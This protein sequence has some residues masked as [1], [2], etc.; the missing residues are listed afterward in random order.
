[1]TGAEQAIIASDQHIYLPAGFEPGWIYELVY[2][3]R[4]PLALD[5]GFAALRDLVSSL[6]ND[7]SPANPLSGETKHPTLFYG[8]GR[9]QSGRLIRDFV[10]RGY[11]DDGFG[12][13]VFDGMI[14]HVAGAGRTA[15]NR[16]SNLVV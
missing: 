4:D 8:W 12:N 6:R 1:I 9:S 10:H 3:A 11:N 5:L 14:S 16:F 2:T 7:D 15:M 13:R